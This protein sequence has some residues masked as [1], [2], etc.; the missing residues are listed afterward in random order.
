MLRALQ[1]VLYFIIDELT[2]VPGQHGTL[3]SDSWEC[4]SGGHYVGIMFIHASDPNKV[5]VLDIVHTWGLDQDADALAE[6]MGNWIEWL[7]SLDVFV[8]GAV[9]D[10]AY[11]M[12][13]AKRK[14]AS[15][16]PGLVMI[17]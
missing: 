14:L 17:P 16:F 4:P 5:F 1:A 12:E 6:H 3:A 7:H 2:S 9:T 15:R 10:N 8:D 13:A 11:V